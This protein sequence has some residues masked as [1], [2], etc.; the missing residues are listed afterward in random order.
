[1][2]AHTTVYA[3][4]K[5]LGLEKFLSSKNFK[6]LV[7][8]S[9]CHFEEEKSFHGQPDAPGTCLHRWG[10]SCVLAVV[11]KTLSRRC[12]RPIDQGLGKCVNQSRTQ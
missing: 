11:L 1:M 7:A 12:Q 2:F 9:R 6:F 5:T 4:E 8:V 10:D 3:C